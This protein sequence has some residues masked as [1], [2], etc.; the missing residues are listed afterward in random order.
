M[1]DRMTGNLA[2]HYERP[3]TKGIPSARTLGKLKWDITTMLRT[4]DDVLR[5]RAEVLAPEKPPFGRPDIAAVVDTGIHG[6]RTGAWV[7]VWSDEG[8][9]FEKVVWLPATR[10]EVYDALRDIRVEAGLI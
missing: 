9:P 6:Q 8:E 10:R 7:Q 3:R 4:K 2:R 1:N 5:F